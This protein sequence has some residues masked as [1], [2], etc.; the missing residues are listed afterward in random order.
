MTDLRAIQ[1]LVNAQGNIQG[2]VGLDGSGQV[3]YGR[4]IPKGK[5]LYALQ[6]TKMEEDVKA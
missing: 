1:P 4:V 2:L 6:W 3:W 5:D